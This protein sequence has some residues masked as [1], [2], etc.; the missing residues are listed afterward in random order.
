MSS[1][2]LIHGSESGLSVE[3]I[4]MMTAADSG[5]GE[6]PEPPAYYRCAFVALAGHPETQVRKKGRSCFIYDSAEPRLMPPYHIHLT[7]ALFSRHILLSF[8]VCHSYNA[9]VD[10]LLKQESS[11]WQLVFEPSVTF[12]QKYAALHHSFFS[13]LNS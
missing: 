7:P 8:Y 2:N 11:D 9:P 1:S 4:G 13:S 6:P 3:I 12:N 5:N 10:I